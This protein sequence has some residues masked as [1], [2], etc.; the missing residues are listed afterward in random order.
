VTPEQYWRIFSNNR[1]EIH[2]AIVLENRNLPILEVNAGY[3][4]APG[5]ILK[6]KRHFEARG[7]PACL[8]LP[9]A[10]NLELEANNAQF[11]R[12]A[13]FAVLEAEPD[14]EPNTKP[15]PIVEQVGWGAARALAKFWCKSVGAQSWE[16]N[17]SSEIARILPSNPNMLAYLAF[18]ADLVIG[19]GFALKG[20][21]HWLTGD[22]QAKTAII[23]RIAFETRTAP[24]F[25][26]PLEQLSEFATV[27]PCQ[28]YAI[29]TEASGS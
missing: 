9:E 22:T 28:R 2:G 26:L 6:I 27:R 16:V 4:N 29:W 3:P 20:A 13:G 14:L 15:G 12:H 5:Q 24:Q 7:R 1:S 17:I 18:D 10:S 23:K 21:V 11:V 25:S 19:L 8:I